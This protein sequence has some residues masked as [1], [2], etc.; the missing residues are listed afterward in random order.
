VNGLEP[1][2]FKDSRK[3]K[4]FT[5][6]GCTEKM[7]KLEELLK[8]FIFVTWFLFIGICVRLKLNQKENLSAFSSTY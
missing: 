8:K 6:N 7:K 1:K 4:I 5:R 2:N 3:M